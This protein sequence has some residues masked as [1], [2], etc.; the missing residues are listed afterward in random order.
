[1]KKRRLYV[2]RDVDTG[3]S[4]FNGNFMYAHGFQRTFPTH[5]AAWKAASAWAKQQKSA[6]D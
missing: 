2:G 4:L 3:W 5:A 6:N 1:M